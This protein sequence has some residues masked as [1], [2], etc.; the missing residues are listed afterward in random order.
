[1]PKTPLGAFLA[2]NPFPHGLTDG[3]FY[4]E[5]M[6]AIHRIAPDR[7]RDDDRPA[8]ILDI[9][10]GRSGLAW[11]LYPEAQI[12]SVD[13]DPELA[14]HGPAAGRVTFVCADALRLPF[15]DGAF[16]AVTLFDV[17][18][19][20][21]D[22][23]QAAAEAAR[24]TRPGGVVLVS[25]PTATWRYPYFRALAPLCPHERELM[26][27]WGHVR[28]GYR[29]D[30]LQALFGK[31]PETQASFINAF[32]ALFHDIAFSRLGRRAR[33]LAYLATSPLA[34]LGYLL[35]HPAMGGAETAGAW[36]R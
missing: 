16:D 12:T 30:E 23:R 6:R 11:L 18:E 35:H 20:I 32:T 2:Q 31:A 1:M 5:K 36:R 10:G 14:G 27:E 26:A 17:L 28:R 15:A 3:L 19:H 9:G 33:K 7:L 24:V 25:T 29:A 21:P 4:R 13:I 34:A 22:D 8:R